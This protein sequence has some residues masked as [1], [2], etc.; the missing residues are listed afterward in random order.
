MISHARYR[1]IRIRSPRTFCGQPLYVIAMGPDLERNEAR[2]TARG[3]IAIGDIAVGFIAI[4]GLARGVFAFGGVS[5][6]VVSFGGASLGMIAL[7]GLAVGAIALGGM[8]MGYYA[9]GG[10]AV[11]KYVLSAAQR[12]DEAVAFFCRFLPGAK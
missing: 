7:G 10:S 6:G 2:G 12:S 4:G 1:S 8:A 11:G 9:L 5:I 3:F